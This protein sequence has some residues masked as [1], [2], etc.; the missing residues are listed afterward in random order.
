MQVLLV[1][2]AMLTLAFCGCYLLIGSDVAVAGLIGG[3][4]AI[5]GSGIAHVKTATTGEFQAQIDM[6]TVAIRLV[7]S[8]IVI[9]TA[10]YLVGGTAAL[11]IPIVWLVLHLVSAWATAMHSMKT[12]EGAL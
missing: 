8:P 11:A 4:I 9:A 5:I 1:Q 7:I 12:A 3:I 6:V 2:A 10:M